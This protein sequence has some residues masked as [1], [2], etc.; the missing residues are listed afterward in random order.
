MGSYGFISTGPQQFSFK[1]ININLINCYAKKLHLFSS[2]SLKA[3]YERNCARSAFEAS[4]KNFHNRS[5]IFRLSSIAINWRRDNIGHVRY[6]ER[7]N[8]PIAFHISRATATNFLHFPYTASTGQECMSHDQQ[9]R[10]IL[11]S[12]RFY[13]GD[14]IVIYQTEL[15]IINE[16]LAQ[17][18]RPFLSKAFWTT[19]AV[20]AAATYP[21]KPVTAAQP[22]I[23]SCY[24]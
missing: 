6:N 2:L 5:V 16:N 11:C 7:L 15:A 24:T 20:A 13:Y 19:T 23:Q 21:R 12:P 18:G 3:Q 9:L 14:N 1:Y 17:R 10:Q 8:G 4:W 22:C